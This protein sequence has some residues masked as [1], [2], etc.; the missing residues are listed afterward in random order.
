[1]KID[2][3]LISSG[4][5]FHISTPESKLISSERSRFPSHVHCVLTQIDGKLFIIFFCFV[6]QKEMILFQL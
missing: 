2:L 5:P 1:M 3:C 4:E 6:I